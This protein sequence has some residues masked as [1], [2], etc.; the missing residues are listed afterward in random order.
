MFIHKIVR[1][2]SDAL[3]LYFRICD[4]KFGER[5]S[6]KRRREPSDFF[7]FSPE[8]KRAGFSKKIF[9]ISQRS[10]EC[11]DLSAVLVV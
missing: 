5:K 1:S 11:A 2:L 3:Q 10:V 7:S 6:A 4:D 8:N 9:P